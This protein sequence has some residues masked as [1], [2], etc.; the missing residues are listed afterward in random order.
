MVMLARPSSLRLR[1]LRESDEAEVIQA[2][3]V[4][5]AE[6]FTFALRWR[7]NLSWKAYLA[8]LE[9]I[10]LGIAVP[11]GLVPAVFLVAEVEG[12][13]VGRASVRFE[14]NDTL[15][16]EG[17]LLGTASCLRSAEGATP[18]RYSARA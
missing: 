9:G 13:I 10:R 4:M 2:H 1:P 6:D 14:L 12:T 7:E 5:A 18:P 17:G 11:E 16:H 3:R 8:L 15:A